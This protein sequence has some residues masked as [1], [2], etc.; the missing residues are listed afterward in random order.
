M[1]E[2]NGA[3][4]IAA[5]LHVLL[6][7]DTPFAVILRR[8]PSKQVC[9]IGWNLSD[10]TFQV[11]Q[12]LKGRIYERNC[13]LSPDGEHLL[14]H[15][16]KHRLKDGYLDYVVLSRTPYL[17]ALKIWKGTIF[18]GGVFLNNDRF[19]LYGFT[20]HDTVFQP[21]IF[22]VAPFGEV[23][24]ESELAQIEGPNDTVGWRFQ[25][26]GWTGS[27]EF[28]NQRSIEWIKECAGWELKMTVRGDDLIYIVRGRRL[29]ERFDCAR[30][31]WADFRGERLLWAQDGKLFASKVWDGG[32]GPIQQLADFNSWTF[33]PIMAPY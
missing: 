26:D 28:Q 31:N 19:A 8:G 21:S 27:N 3:A 25:R 13:D 1:Y 22:R 20:A 17:K 16:V 24:N 2:K 15:A 10:D 23:K 33:E 32:Y 5:R 9:T 4:P 29:G 7:R 14:Y 30:W 11:G 12:W 6:A 18:H